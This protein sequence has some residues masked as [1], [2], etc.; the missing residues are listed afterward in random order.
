MRQ[1]AKRLAPAGVGVAQG[2]ALADGDVV[3]VEIATG[4]CSSATGAPRK[5]LR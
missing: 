2:K 4:P 5:G 3:R 1:P